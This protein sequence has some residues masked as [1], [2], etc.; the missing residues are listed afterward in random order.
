MF[1]FRTVAVAAVAALALVGAA[2]QPAEAGS[3]APNRGRYAALGDSYAAG[4]GASVA[5][6]VL[7][8][9]AA[10]KVNFLAV[11]G[12][13]TEDVIANQVHRVTPGVR[14]VT[15]TVGGNDVNFGG[16]TQAC[17][18]HPQSQ[19]CTDAVNLGFSQI[20]ALPERVTALIGDVRARAPRAEIYVTG[21]PILFQ[22]SQGCSLPLPPPLLG[23]I[24]GAN[25]SLNQA[26]AGAVMAANDPAVS[27]VDVT[28]K[29][30][31][32]GLCQGESLIHGT[33]SDTPLH[34]TQAGQ[35]AYAA[36]LA[37]AGFPTAKSQRS[38][39]QARSSHH[40]RS[41]ASGSAHNPR[42]PASGS[43]KPACRAHACCH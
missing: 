15:I 9:G 38:R 16:V 21:Y 1:R 7:V 25:L 33:Q 34:P 26:I 5:Y 27:Y 30:L 13:T 37:E 35:K 40:P 28:N 23:A 29:F 6:P 8:A 36:A 32:Q 18:A 17:S 22:S 14:Q 4:F 41:P 31:G 2:A 43:A 3:K 12:A 11:S 24:D 19:A 39:S 42:S 20:A 10:N